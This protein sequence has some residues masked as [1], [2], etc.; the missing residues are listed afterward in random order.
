[1]SGE[2]LSGGRPGAVLAQAREAQSITTREVA[3]ALHLPIHVIDAI[4]RGDKGGLPAYVFTRGYVRA[5]AKL[6]EL[7]PDPLV[8]A[9]SQEY[10]DEDLVPD[11]PNGT[12]ETLHTVND[13]QHPVQLLQA[14]LKWVAAG[15][16]VLVVLLIVLWPAGDDPTDMGEA[17]NEETVQTP[18][19]QVQQQAPDEE[20][21][22]AD[23]QQVGAAGQAGE[24]VQ[25]ATQDIASTTPPAA[26]STDSAVTDLATSLD[27]IEIFVREDCWIEIK[28]A[29][30]SV[31]YGDLGRTGATVSLRDTG[32]FSVLLGYAPGVDF[33]YNGERIPLA[34]HT[35]NNVATFVI[36][37]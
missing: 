11:K 1:M 29:D 14:N 35:R 6:M 13:I 16:V 23:D 2:D 36:G 33:E 25:S 15:A 32:P 4:E 19:S 7:D 34:P 30:G 31:L 18:V 37:Q 24:A 28:R 27:Q 9:L 10:G 17:V 8:T 26:A 21:A 12:D 5:Y 3:D 22:A 20:R